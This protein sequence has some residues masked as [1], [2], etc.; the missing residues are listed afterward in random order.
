M[1]AANRVGVMTSKA[2]SF[3]TFNPSDRGTG[4]TLSGGDRTVGGGGPNVWTNVRSRSSRSAGKWYLEVTSLSAAGPL[5]SFSIGVA[6]GSAA[7]GPSTPAYPGTDTN[8]V[9]AYTS[10]TRAYFNAAIVGTGTNSVVPNGGVLAMAVDLD[11][12]SVTWYLNGTQVWTTTSL[13]TGS[14]FVI[15]GTLGGASASVNFGQDAF[16]YSPPAGHAG[17]TV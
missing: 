16:I 9:G 17:F 5:V 13:P 3:D 15:A 1:F 7:L 10:E 12:R 2:R 11:A 4:L 14:V 8:S 6:T